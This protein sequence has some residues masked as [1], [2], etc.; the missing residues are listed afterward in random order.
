RGPRLRTP[1]SRAEQEP[2]HLRTE[3][4]SRLLS[5]RTSAPARSARRAPPALGT[6]SPPLDVESGVPASRGRR[7]PSRG[8]S[9]FRNTCTAPGQITRALGLARSEEHTSEL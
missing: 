8:G 9:M 7:R 3:T 4:S 6:V 1:P 5:C 2:I